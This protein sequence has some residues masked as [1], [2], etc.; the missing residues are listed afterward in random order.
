MARPWYEIDKKLNNGI[1]TL[2]CCILAFSFKAYADEPEAA[3]TET[4]DDELEQV[5]VPERPSRTERPV[6][7]ADTLASDSIVGKSLE[8]AMAEDSL[9]LAVDTVPQE[10]EKRIFFKPDPT[11]AVW[12]SALCPGLGQIYNRRYW[13]LPIVVGGYVGLIY[14]T[15]W[16]SRMLSDY[17]Q[18]YIDVM[19]NDP[20]TK[21][22]MEFYPPTTKEEDLDIEWLKKSFKSKKDF[23]RRNRDLCIISM[24]GLYLVCMIDAYVDASL[25]Q[26]DISPNLSMQWSPAV[27]DASDRTRT[28]G[29]QCAFS[30]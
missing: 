14:A 11:R 26:F 17:T 9:S 3:G 8:I 18:A 25:S 6:M 21:S 29:V 30:F 13:K 2:L 27:F 12:L 19:D 20:N 5:I 10:F 28:I 16:N 15:S 7:P 23:Y 22:Y 4:A 1:V 24:V